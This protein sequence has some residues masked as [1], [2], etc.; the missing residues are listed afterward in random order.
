MRILIAYLLTILLYFQVN[1]AGCNCVS[2]A[3]TFQSCL[4]AGTDVSLTGSFTMTADV[5]IPSATTVNLTL[6][7]F[8]VQFG[9]FSFF[10]GN[11]GS[12]LVIDGF[13]LVK[14]SGGDMTFAELTAHGSFGFLLPVEFIYFQL[15]KSLGAVHINW[16][17]G[18][19]TNNDFFL[20]ERSYNGTDWRAIEEIKGAG[21]SNQQIEYNYTDKS[22]E[23]D[24][25]YYRIKQV[26][27]DG[28]FEYSDV[29]SI[30]L[31]YYSVGFQRAGDMYASLSSEYNKVQL[32]NLN[33]NNLATSLDGM[34]NT[35]TLSTGIYVLVASNGYE[36]YVQKIY[37]R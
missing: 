13:T 5:T 32:F 10:G 12:K 14:D 3:A 28:A 2:D 30:R 7:G 22:I 1:A 37:V 21:N 27:F 9:G 26:D 23:A 6:N 29:K 11:N 4:N 8:N 36:K 34:M 33:G 17:T 31:N 25:A 35:S 20:I 19:E 24:L 15:L 16:A 18:S